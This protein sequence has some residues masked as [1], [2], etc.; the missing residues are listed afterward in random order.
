MFNKILSR[1]HT[2]IIEFSASVEVSEQEKIR[3]Q[4]Y[5]IFMLLGIPTMLIFGL[6]NLF[7]ANHFI[8]AFTLVAACCLM[9]GG[10][11]LK[12]VKN[13]NLI[14][15]VNTFIYVSLVGSMIIIG[16][17]GGSKALWAYVVPLICCFLFGKKEGGMWSMV[18]L[19][20]A[21]FAFSQTNILSIE[22]YNYSAS[23]KVRFIIT[24][25]FCTII[26]IW[27]E[28]SR[29]Y[30]LEK[31]EAISAD[32]KKE[33]IKL[34][35][36]IEYRKELEQELIMIARID[37]LTGILNRGAFFSTAEKHWNK[38]VRSAQP[39][40]L[41]I[42][43]IDHFKAVNDQFGHPAGDDVLIKLTQCCANSIRSFDVFGRIGGEEFGLLFAETDLTEA[44]LI[45]ERLR[46]S[47]ESTQIEYQ[48][49]YISCTISI[50]LFCII[51]PD[52]VLTVMYKNA[53]F[54]LYQA[55]NSGRNK[56][57]SFTRI[58]PADPS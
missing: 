41:A 22:V 10:L 18:V 17:T 6:V 56:I 31:S 43:D 1:L 13:V 11:A 42:L 53:D 46:L 44:E 30:F 24:Y 25:V 12:Q 15:R 38:H 51:P 21:I 47:I 54:A 16:G 7:Q 32:L 48:G 57:C 33:H 5:I 14:Y 23:F 45:L 8:F 52:E 34:K 39:L 35:A 50:G 49:Q 37:P 36:E 27:L 40:S 9:I 2:K 58:N 20:I 4:H 55:K 19:I 26:S 29:H 28:N 3:I